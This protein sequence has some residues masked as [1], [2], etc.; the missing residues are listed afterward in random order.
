M[1]F[2]YLGRR[3]A[4]KNPVAEV[5]GC[6][7]GRGPALCVMRWLWLFVRLF[8]SDRDF[9]KSA[10]YLFC[11]ASIQVLSNAA[12]LAAERALAGLNRLYLNARCIR[13]KGPWPNFKASLVELVIALLVVPLEGVNL[14]AYL[15]EKAGRRLKSLGDGYCE[16]WVDRYK[17]RK[18]IWEQ[19][20]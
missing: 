19:T 2:N 17:T 20:A 18:K 13:T 16:A 1:F 14:V 8:V 4:R 5:T 10:V 12:T 9:R 3:R 11:A 15:L 6:G 7:A